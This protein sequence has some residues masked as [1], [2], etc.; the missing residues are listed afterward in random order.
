MKIGIGLP[1]TTPGATGELIVSWARRAEQRGF[2]TLA[3]I[4]RI[5]YPNF[6]SLVTLAAA[7]AVTERIGLFTNILLGPTRSTALLAKEAASVEQIS[8][9]R[10]TLGLAVGGRPDDFDLTGLEF[11]DR[12]KRFDRQLRDLREA[13]AG[14]PLPGFDGPVAPEPVRPG[15]PPIVIGGMHD[16]AVRRT[17]EFAVGWSV[18][19]GQPEHM[20]P[21]VQRVRGAW[22]AAGRQGDPYFYA[23]AY[24]GLGE[25]HVEASKHSILDYY[26]F[27]GDGAVGLAE[28]LPRT[29]ER[30]REYQQAY[31][32]AGVD[33]IVWDPTVPDLDQ[34][35]LLADAVLS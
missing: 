30:I 21:M 26:A 6:D 2:S 32:E 29:P 5:A 4:D 19:G 18:G 1:N 33:E 25:E 34:V 16:A 31:E 10:L 23:L 20:A 28:S 13:L 14:K 3:T 22:A 35:D 15:G 8:G 12:G 27:I 17:A 11:H 24:F 7:G 9:G